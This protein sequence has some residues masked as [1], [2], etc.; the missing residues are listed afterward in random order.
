MIRAREGHNGFGLHSKN[1][2][3]LLKGFRY[4]DDIIVLFFTRAL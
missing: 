3:K 1:A 4:H 2:G